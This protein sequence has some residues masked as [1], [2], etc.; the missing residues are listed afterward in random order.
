MKDKRRLPTDGGPIKWT[1]PFATLK[2]A[3]LPPTSPARSVSGQTDMVPAVP[4]KNRGRVDIIRQT[5]HRG[6]KTV[7]VVTGFVGIGQAE[8]ALLAKRMQK[9]CGAGGTVKEG[10]I[11]IQGDQREA[12][13]RILIDAGFR[14][15]FA[16]G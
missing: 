16:G 10:K 8:K 3:E 2:Q 4:K 7:T 11:E 13:A 15:V 5:A 9:V 12:V 6:G 14:P 1:S